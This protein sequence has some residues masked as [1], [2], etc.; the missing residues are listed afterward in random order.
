MLWFDRSNF[1]A[2]EIVC[3]AIAAIKLL[4]TETW[5]LSTWKANHVIKEHSSTGKSNAA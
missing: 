5:N 4:H 1:K 3:K 2:F